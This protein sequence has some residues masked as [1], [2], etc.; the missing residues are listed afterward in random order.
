MPL[1]RIEVTREGVT[2]PQKQQLIAE[3]TEMMV[4]VLGKDPATTFVII[5]EVETDNWGVAGRS[6]TERRKDETTA[7]GRPV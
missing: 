1:I 5:D 2:Q 4:R 7:R 3:A 6:V